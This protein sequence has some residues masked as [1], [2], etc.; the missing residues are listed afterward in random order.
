MFFNPLYPPILGAWE[1]GGYPQA[2]MQRG[3]SPLHSPASKHSYKGEGFSNYC[4]SPF[5]CTI[6]GKG[7]GMPPS[8]TL[9][10]KDW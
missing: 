10:A 6:R 4:S 9:V 5:A 7:L 3:E 8:F 2:P 1:L